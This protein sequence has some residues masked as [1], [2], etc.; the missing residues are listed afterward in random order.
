MFGSS[1]SDPEDDMTV[2]SI[3]IVLS[4]SGSRSFMSISSDNTF[5]E[6]F[7]RLLVDVKGDGHC[8]ERVPPLLSLLVKT[9]GLENNNDRA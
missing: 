6:A 5:H 3:Y 1:E 9:F 4:S 2:P 8:T 7:N